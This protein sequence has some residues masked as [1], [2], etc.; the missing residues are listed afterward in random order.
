M[1]LEPRFIPFRNLPGLSRLF[2]DYVDLSPA[3]LRFYQNPPAIPDLVKLAREVLPNLPYARPVLQPILERQ[4]AA[5]G[6][7][8]RTLQNIRDFGQDDSVAVM[9][10]QQVGL[11]TGPLYTIHKALAALRVADC[12]RTAGVRAVPIFWMECEDH[13]LAE[14]THSTALGTD[15]VPRTLNFRE[16]LFGDSRDAA[17]PVGTLVLPG[18]IR[19]VTAEFAGLLQDGPCRQ[20]VG[21]LL[22]EAYRPGAGLADAFGVLMTRLFRHHGLVFFNPAEREAKGLVAPVFQEAL[23][24]SDEIHGLL[25]ER[26]EA[27]EAAGYHQQV[28]ILDNSTV[29]FM[30][31]E[32][33][34]RALIRV[35][36]LMGWKN[37]D[38]AWPVKELVDLAGQMPERFSPSV[39][40]RPLIQDH[41]FPT[42]AYVGGPAEVAYF[43]QIEVLYRLWNRP[44]PAIWPRASFTL[45]EPE[46]HSAMLES[47]IRLTDC[48]Q[49]RQLLVEK[50][51][52]HAAQ[53]DTGSKLVNLGEELA[54][55]LTDIRPELVLAE[56]SLGAA[57]DTAQR[58][59]QHNLKALH[60]KLVQLE[61]QRNGVLNQRADLI[62]SHCFPNKNL[63]ERV[64][65]APVFLAR[66]GLNLIDTLY[67]EVKVESFAHRLVAL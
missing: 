37:T 39:L 58:K 7:G 42:A 3:A 62:L 55:V 36:P 51:T 17:R 67:S 63:Q 1:K 41:L 52:A 4:N 25:K 16:R 46:V 26:N 64:F 53:S 5:L 31:E 24:R 44:M 2:L 45:L 60:S 65:G 13:D 33:E 29:V 47:G 19:E 11:F 14:V 61:A 27:L 21:S 48:F 34:R 22:D 49:G 54:R 10:G 57:L 43:A 15:F 23:R 32:N 20:E 28:S 6:A 50:I 35:G 66:H 59:I 40:L 38:R 56:A 12:L 8:E 30:R 18:A 9:T